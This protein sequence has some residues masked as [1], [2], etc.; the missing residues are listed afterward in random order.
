VDERNVIEESVQR[1]YTSRRDAKTFLPFLLPHLRAGMEILD[2][3]CGLGSIALDLAPTVAPG[4]VVGIDID[5][6]SVEAARRSAADRDVKNVEF[7]TGSVFELPFAD[8]TFDAVYAN[9][10][11]MYVRERPRA[12]AEMRRVLRPGGVAAVIDDDHSTFVVSPDCPELVEAFHLMGQVIAQDGG[13]ARYSSRL[14][15]MMLEAGFVRT[16]G[17]ANAPE[18]Y[19]DAASTA[20]FADLVASLY[21]DPRDTD[22]IIGKGWASRADLDAAVVAIR[23]WAERPDAFLSWLYCGALGW[24]G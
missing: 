17:V 22:V 12:L 18:V 20:F 10:V 8:E 6:K 5:A 24:T 16:Q 3:G 14:R 1:R 19:G 9:T 23:E 21:N 11:L 4:R 15:S 2:A 7:E 13:D